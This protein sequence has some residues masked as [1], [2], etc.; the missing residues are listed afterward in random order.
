MQLVRGEDT[1]IDLL[2]LASPFLAVTLPVMALVAALAVGFEA[3]PGLRGGLGNVVYFIF[4]MTTL[5][6]SAA[7]PGRGT[8]ILGSHVIIMQMQEACA[9]AYPDYPAGGALAMGFNIKS[10]GV[11]DLQTFVWRGA[12]WPP[13]ALAT[14]A[15]YFVLAL[16]VP[17][18]AA[19][20]FDRFDART[21]DARKRVPGRVRK[22]SPRRSP[23]PARRSPAVWLWA[24]LR[25]SRG[26]RASPW[27]WPASWARLAKHP[28]PGGGWAG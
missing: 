19:L 23:G 14:R 10:H 24:S 27:A 8:D 18:A 11:W 9:R 3:V 5:S 7:H 1:H 17:L 15:L 16:A 25:G 13:A 21:A 6:L 12:A 22:A 20:V 28:P 26:V 4:W 2:A